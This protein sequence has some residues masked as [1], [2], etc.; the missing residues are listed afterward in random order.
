MDP[1]ALNELLPHWKELGAPLE[2]A[3]HRRRMLFLSET[4]SSAR[5][6]PGARLLP[7]RRQLRRRLGARVK[8]LGEQAEAL[9]VDDLP[10]LH[11][12]PRCS[13]T[14]AR[15]RRVATGNL[16]LGKDGEPTDNFQLGMELHARNTRCS[17]KAAR[18]HLGK[19]LD[20]PNSSS[21]KARTRRPTPSA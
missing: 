12:P 17:P 18:G 10:R 15:S 6:T 13:T 7:Q 9:G 16:G 3:R 8:W 4:G 2:P 11:R 5:P 1:R 21:T 19:E 14:T 20:Q